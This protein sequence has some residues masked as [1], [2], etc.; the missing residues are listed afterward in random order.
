MVWID[1]WQQECC[2]EPS[3]VGAAVTWHLAEPDHDFQGPPFPEGSGVEITK[4]Y[5][6][7]EIHSDTVRT[8]CTILSIDGVWCLRAAGWPVAGSATHRAFSA[9]RDAGTG[10]RDG[11]AGYLVKVRALTTSLR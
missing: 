4:I 6:H 11:F 7:H 9:L 2:G 10:T 1:G 5:D 3:H 8:D